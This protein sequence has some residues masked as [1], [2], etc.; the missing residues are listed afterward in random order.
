MKYLPYILIAAI[1]L[2]LFFFFR[3]P[4]PAPAPQPEPLDPTGAGL[5]W[6]GGGGAGFQPGDITGSIV[7]STPQVLIVPPVKKIALPSVTKFLGKPVN[8]V[9]KPIPG[10]TQLPG[11]TA[12]IGANPNKPRFT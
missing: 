2:G 7:Q 4:K 6:G 9:I 5:Q 10:T 12:V 8:R 1:A 3:K 11:T